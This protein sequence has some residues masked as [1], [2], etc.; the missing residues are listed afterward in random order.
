MTETETTTHVTTIPDPE[1]VVDT[2][3]IHSNCEIEDL[4]AS[5]ARTHIATQR[6]IV[7][8]HGSVELNVNGDIVSVASAPGHPKSFNIHQDSTGWS[9]VTRWVHDDVEDEDG[10]WCETTYLRVEEVR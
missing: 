8:L 6:L 3:T 2:V 7:G 1:N 9:W 5:V 4:V 10:N